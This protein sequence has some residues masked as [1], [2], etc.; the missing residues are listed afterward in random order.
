MS[1]EPSLRR[2]RALVI[3]VDVVVIAL[4]LAGAEFALRVRSEGGAAAA[5]ASFFGGSVRL[6]SHGESDW[7][8][9][10][11]V[12]GYRLNTEHE[13]VNSLGIRHGE[14]SA[15]RP[16][17]SF[18]M[19]VLGDSISWQQEGW[20]GVLARELSDSDRTL[21]VVN[22]AIPGY[23]THQ[24]RLLFETGLAATR[25][26]LV[27]L[28][29]CFNDN[30]EFLHELT[31]DGRWLVRRDAKQALVPEGDGLLAWLSR[32]SYLAFEVRKRLYLA[33]LEHDGSFPWESNPDFA[34]AWQRSSW[35]RQETELALLRDAAQAV[36][37]ELVVVAVPY[38]LQ[39]AA[40]YLERDREYVLFP[41][42]E[43]T[44]VCV[45]LGLRVLD[46]QPAFERER[47]AVLYVEGDP[48]HLS[49]AGHTVLA[50]EVEAFLERE[51]LRP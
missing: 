11:P 32:R 37:S 15:E 13:P 22:A 2:R 51:G 49:P 38:E 41:Q 31:D 7:L 14:L 4:V 19:L 35:E 29:Y 25:P 6:A 28:Q 3:A 8:E 18:R 33:G 21:E 50:R 16:A 5:W 20:V 39:I 43:L 24:E 10:H 36:G 47:D 26:D 30:H 40:K 46:V 42:H 1:T 17:N 48:V 23:T 9:P 12:L 45:E 44:R 27:L 34:P